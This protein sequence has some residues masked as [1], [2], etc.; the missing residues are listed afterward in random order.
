MA[1]ES[2]TSPELEQIPEYHEAKRLSETIA[3]R[4]GVQAD[5]TTKTTAVP[6]KTPEC[7][8]SPS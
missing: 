2:E 6:P 5:N 4:A 1:I 8:C 7:I 3:R